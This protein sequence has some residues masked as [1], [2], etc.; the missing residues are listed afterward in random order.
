[1]L[2]AFLI[3]GVTAMCQSLNGT[4]SVGRL[5]STLGLPE[6]T[7]LYDGNQIPATLQSSFNNPPSAWRSGGVVVYWPS[8]LDSLPKCLD[9]NS[10]FKSNLRYPKAALE[11]KATGTV[12]VQFII[13]DTCSLEEISVDGLK[14]G[15]SALLDSLVR[16]YTN[17]LP[18]KMGQ[19][20]VPTQ[21]SFSVK[22][23]KSPQESQRKVIWDG[24]PAAL[25]KDVDA[26]T[27]ARLKLQ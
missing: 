22:F 18:G 12:T 7:L 27:F 1:M 17:W 21:I 11:K 6:D 14:Y 4:I 13:T 3:C 8:S 15:C 25:V 26:E 20:A 2:F 19:I 9:C 5:D 10:F 16:N 24:F 23:H